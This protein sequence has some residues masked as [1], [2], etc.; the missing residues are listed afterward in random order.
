MKKPN[1]AAVHHGK[2]KPRESAM[3]VLSLEERAAQLIEIKFKAKCAFV[4]ATDLNH[5]NEI[6]PGCFCVCENALYTVRDDPAG[7]YEVTEIAKQPLSDVKF[8]PYVG[9]IAIECKKEGKPYELCRSTYRCKLAF[10]EAAKWMRIYLAGEI[11]F[12]Q[13][14]YKKRRSTCPKCG[15][16]YVGESEVCY[17]CTDKKATVKQL[18]KVAKPQLPLFAVSIF[19][20]IITTLLGVVIPN[21]Q[22]VGIDDYIKSPSPETV[23]F[24]SLLLVVLSIAGIALLIQLL[25]ILRNNLLATVGNKT[26]ITL[27]SMLYQKIQLMS[28]ASISRRSAGELINRVTGDTQQI[29]DFMTWNLPSIIEQTLMFVVVGVAMFIYNAPLALLILI[30]VPLVVLMFKSI[31]HYAHRVYHRQW[32]ADANAST[33]LHDIFQGVRVVKVFGTEQREIE[34]YNTS[35]KTVADIQIKNETIWN[36]IM[37]YANFLLGAGSFIVLYYVGGR[38]LAGEMT[39]GEMQMFSYYTG[40]LYGPLRWAAHLPRMIQ[41][42]LTSIS[43]VFEIINEETDVKDTVKP[44]DLKIR[45]EVEFDNASFGY[46]EVEDVL[47]NITLSI[48]PGEMLGIVGKS[49]VGKSTL[50]NLVMRLYDVRSG[51]VKI[52]GVDIRDISQSSLRSQIGVVLQE[53]FLFTGSVYDNIAYAKPD[54]THEEVISA[55]KLANAHNFIMKLPDSYNTYVGE[56]GY[57]LSGGERQRI[58]IARAVLHNPKILILDEATSAL[59]T[60]TEKMIQ[61]SLAELT[62]NRTTL[63][64][65]HRLSTLRNA[66]KLVVLDEGRVAEF[67]THEE[68]MHKNGIYYN[69]VMAQRQMNK[70]SK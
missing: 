50:I 62:K 63:A 43:K 9:Y 38:I 68:L 27:R 18:F 44:V 67:G 2:G 10:S 11:P 29:S 17:D 48:K 40:I 55:S 52:D 30:P 3:D 60:E 33:V 61:D 36:T 7:G 25:S 47:K 12:S 41:Q 35:I 6:G 28:V 13:I 4:L 59:D 70:L 56:K 45:G 22:R 23:T 58:A 1:K 54:A 57:T 64:I 16:P 53:T 31:W 34:K 32:I 69:L 66:T 20:F 5:E 39:L 15:M 42:A 8:N 21:I 65:A 19:L 46:T 24:S 37:P 49:G 51:C 14:K 26:V